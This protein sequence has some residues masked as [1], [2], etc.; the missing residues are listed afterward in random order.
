MGQTTITVD[1]STLERFK[2]LKEEHSE[3]QPETPEHTADTFL[4]ALM[5]TWEH[6]KGNTF[7]QSP[8]EEIAKELQDE[9]TMA[10]EAGEAVDP[11][12]VIKR[13]DDL[14]SQLPRKI[15]REL[16]GD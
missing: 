15:A 10:K 14:E 7:T 12:T 13:I 1:E 11:A 16:Q 4:H 5:D 3:E 8:A 2:T 9:L 6:A